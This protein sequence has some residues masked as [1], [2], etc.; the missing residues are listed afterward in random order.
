[1]SSQ[2]KS[3]QDLI[4]WQKAYRLILEVYEV[5]RGW[6]ADERFTLTQQ[7]R[8]AALSIACNIAEGWGRGTR[9]DYKR[10]VQMSRGSTYELQTQMWV[11]RD[12]RYIGGDHGVFALIEEVDRLI[13]GLLRAL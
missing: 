11:A 7:V 3:Y 2:I 12:L 10:F 1:M 9:A 6:P 13:N 5:S 8:R 4:A